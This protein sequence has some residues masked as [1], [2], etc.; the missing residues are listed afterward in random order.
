MLLSNS[1]KYYLKHQPKINQLPSCKSFNP[2]YPDSDNFY[3]FISRRDA[4]KTEKMQKLS[5]FICVY[6]RLIFDISSCK[7]FNPGYPDSDKFFF[8][9]RTTET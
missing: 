1:E 9:K 4:E 7:S 8:L 5:A 3:F 2:G 6:L